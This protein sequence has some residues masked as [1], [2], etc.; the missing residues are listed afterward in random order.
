MT[1]DGAIWSILR[2]HAPK[3][4][5]ISMDEIFAIIESHVVFDFEDMEI[6]NPSLGNPRWKHN[7][8]HLLKLKKERG[9]IRTRK[10]K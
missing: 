7:V 4:R 5:W 2:Y 3:K 6:V 8:R 9:I 10:K 1:D